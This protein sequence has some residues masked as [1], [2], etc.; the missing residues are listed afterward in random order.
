MADGTK[1]FVFASKRKKVG[2]TI[3]GGFDVDGEWYDIR[4]LRDTAVAVLVHRI[5]EADPG[6]VVGLV[7]NFT[8][9]ALTPASAKRFAEIVLDPVDGLEILEIMEVFQYVLGVVGA[10]PTGSVSD[11]STPPPKVGTRSRR[12][13]ATSTP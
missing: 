13:V 6:E 1:S 11:S 12:G 4:A 8:E 5:G 3:V 2:D 9:K 7:L 10:N